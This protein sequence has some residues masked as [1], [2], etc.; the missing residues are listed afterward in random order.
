MHRSKILAIPAAVACLVCAASSA[1]GSD[2]TP[3]GGGLHLRVAP[4]TRGVVRNGQFRVR[5]SVNYSGPGNSGDIFLTFVAVDGHARKLTPTLQAP[6]VRFRRPYTPGATTFL[7][8]G[9]SSAGTRVVRAT[10]AL[11]ADGKIC[12]RSP[13]AWLVENPSDYKARTAAF[14]NYAKAR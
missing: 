5:F 9:V 10:F 3:A 7:V 6:G 1:Y 12:V 11:R 13:R 2:D 4:L 14:C 8:R